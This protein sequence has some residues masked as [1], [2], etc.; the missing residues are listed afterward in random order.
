VADYLALDI[1]D[2]DNFVPYIWAVNR[3]NEL[4]KLAVSR[5]LIH[6]CRDR[7][8]F[9]H[10][11]QEMAGIHSRY[12]D[13]AKILIQA[14]ADEEIANQIAQVKAQFEAQLEQVKTET[15]ANVMSR[16]TDMLLGMDL[17]GS[18][19]PV[20]STASV[21]SSE[22]SAS[23][24][25]ADSTIQPDE[26]SVE[27]EAEDKEIETFD[28]AW[29][30][31]PLCTTCNDCTD[32]NPLMFVYNDTNQA[33]IADLSAGTYKQMVEAAEICPSRCIYPGK[34]WDESEADLED[35]MERAAPFNSF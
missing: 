23:S 1:N 12:I 31:S 15:A 32:M 33:I 21:V 4:R 25:S 14:R 24:P 27:E 28:E 35:L 8:N 34:P 19:V 26:Q 7:L 29:I 16:L 18:G 9:W 5:A 10:S 22:A 17:S 6:A 13:D 20:R 2:V 3:D 11:L 30:D